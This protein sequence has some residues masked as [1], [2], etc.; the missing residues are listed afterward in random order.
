MKNNIKFVSGETYNLSELFSGNRRIIIPDLQ[1]DYCW[2]DEVHTQEKKDLVSGFVKNLISLFDKKEGNDGGLNLGLIYG[3]EA[4]V[5]HIQLCDGQQRITTLFLLIGVLNKKVYGNLFKRYLISD[6][7]YSLDDREPYLQYSVRETSLYFLSDLVCH[8]FVRDNDDIYSVDSIDAIKKSSWFFND[9]NTDP[10]IQ[11]MLKAITKI[12]TILQE[13]GELWCKNFGEYITEQLTFMYYDMGNRRNGEETFVVINTTGEPLSATQNLKPLVLSADIN[14][15]YSSVTGRS[16]AADWEEIETW[17]WQRRAGENDTADAGFN[18]FMRWVTM[19]ECDEEDLIKEMLAEGRYIFPKEKISF[20][21]VYDIYKAVDFLFEKWQWKACLSKDFLSP[22]LINEEQKNEGR[23][24]SQIDC[25]L[26]LPL[27]AYCRRWGVRDVQDRNLLR[28]YNFLHNLTR[29]DNVGK[30]VNELVYDVV[31]LA[32]KCCDV[33]DVLN[34]TR[35][36]SSTILTEEEVC[37]LRILRDNV[38]IREVVEE[39]FWEAQGHEI[40]CGQIMPLIRWAER[41]GNFDVDEFRRYKSK[42]EEVFVEDC[43]IVRRALLTRRLKDYPR[44]FRGYTNISFCWEWED[45]KLLINDNVD[46]FKSFFD[47]LCSGVSFDDM[48]SGFSPLENY[49]E[50]VRCDYLLAYC[51]EKNIQRSSDQGVI[52]IKK[53]RATKYM[54]TV[55]MHLKKYLERNFCKDNWEI[56]EYDSEGTVVVENVALNIVFDIYVSGAQWVI[57]FFKRN[58]GATEAELAS[59]VDVDWSFKDGAFETSLVLG[60]ALCGLYEFPGVLKL[61]SDV[62][63]RIDGRE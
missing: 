34:Y 17:F 46:A 49:A 47:D 39:L 52:L 57:K 31:S 5:N 16:V 60:T 9:Y 3:Y 6:F 11:S 59:F 56:W 13:K 25:F 45:W 36:V 53:R 44:F 12:E 26:L 27:I 23:Y 58:D 20:A 10:S 48:I 62:V 4:P 41:D 51:E 35:D 18:E 1:R 50:F 21:D 37:K 19:L 42:V 55:C 22:P 24:I 38:A 32:K 61:L 2:G 33:V 28:L 54:P 14:S 8:Y 7:E 43:D 30:G 15:S 29:L 63:G 40:W